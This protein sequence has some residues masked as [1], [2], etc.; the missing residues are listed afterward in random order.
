MPALTAYDASAGPGDT[1]RQARF[2]EAFESS[3]REVFACVLSVLPDRSEADDVF[4]DVCAVL[5]RKFDEFEAGTSFTRWACA[6]AFREAKAHARRRRRRG[7]VRLDEAA[8]LRVEV[9]RA[10]ASELLELKREMLTECLGKLSDTDRAL[11]NEFYAENVTA[12]EYAQRHGLSKDGVYVKLG[13][14]RRRL[15]DCV[16]RGLGGAAK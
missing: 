6:V 14:L 10:A 5:W 9:V 16:Q 11:L 1:G 7:S 13:R 8:L 15:F 3:S 2:V 12:A 4:Q